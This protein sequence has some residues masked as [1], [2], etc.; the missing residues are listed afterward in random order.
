[1][2]LGIFLLKLTEGNKNYP[3]FLQTETNTEMKT[4]LPNIAYQLKNNVSISRFSSD[5][6][7][8]FLFVKC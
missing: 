8:L 3:K 6:I 2:D 7:K 5:I 1:M 4:K